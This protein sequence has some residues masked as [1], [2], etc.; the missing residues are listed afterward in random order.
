KMHQEMGMPRTGGNGQCRG[1]SPNGL[2]GVINYNAMGVG[3]MEGFAVASTDTGHEGGDTAWMQAPDKVTDFAGR[4]M[5]E[6]TVAGKAF[7][8]DYYGTAPKYAY[9]IECGGGSAA[10][11]HEVQQY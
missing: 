3:L 5:H 4:A 9:M 1:T 11:L 2:G 8:T 6:T 10:A 7:A